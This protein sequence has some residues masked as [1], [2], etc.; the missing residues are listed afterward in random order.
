VLSVA[1]SQLK[2]NEIFGAV[3]GLFIGVAQAIY[4]W[5]TYHK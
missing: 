5:F 3:I 4:F 2:T 1:Q